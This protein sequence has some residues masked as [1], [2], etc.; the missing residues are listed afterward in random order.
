MNNK[1][2]IIEE[3]KKIGKLESKAEFQ[4]FNTNEDTAIYY[5]KDGELF[6]EICV[7]DPTKVYYRDQK[8]LELILGVNILYLSHRIF[9]EDETL[10]NKGIT[11]ST[12]GGTQPLLYM[13]D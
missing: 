12:I 5:L 11:Y 6:H 13:N 1:E 10:F 2:L 3:F 4:C 9:N 7:S 8:V